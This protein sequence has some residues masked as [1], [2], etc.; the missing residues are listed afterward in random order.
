MSIKLVMPSNHFI[1]CYPLLPLPSI[2][3]SIR[4]FSNESV[5]WIKWPKYWSFSISCS[6]EYSGMIS[7]MMD[8]LDLRVVKGT[9]KSLL[10]HHSSKT[11]FFWCS[12]FF[13]IQL[14]Y[15]Y[16]T[17]GKTVAL[18][19]WTFIGKV[20]SLLFNML[21]RFV[22]AFLLKS[23]FLLISWLYSPS[24]VIL[25][26]KKIKSL[27]VSIVTPSICNEGLDVMIFVF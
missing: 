14:S 8:Y 27:T 9:L 6:N 18:T 15:P 21:S 10:Q 23:K 22:I 12:A 3:H 20:M 11:S 1:L 5:L 4:F 16:M 17:I 24:A 19:K 7:F 25:E 26:P 2:F 13:M